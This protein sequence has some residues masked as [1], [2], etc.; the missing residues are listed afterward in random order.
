MSML[1]YRR[2]HLLLVL[3]LLLVAIVP[4][5]AGTRVQSAQLKLFL[6]MMIVPPAASPFGFAVRSNARDPVLP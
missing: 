5:R 1:R 2:L 3:P 4:A 6:P